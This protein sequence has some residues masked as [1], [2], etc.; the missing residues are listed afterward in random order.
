MLEEDFDETP[1]IEENELSQDDLFDDDNEF[2]EDEDSVEG[3]EESS[4]EEESEEDKAEV[5]RLTE[6]LEK[7]KSRLHDTQQGFHTVCQERAN[8]RKRLEE[9]EAKEADEDEWFSSSDD[10][11]L[12]RVRE[13]YARVEQVEKEAL[14]AA[15][16]VE[17]EQ[18]EKIMAIWESKAR[19]VRNS[20]SDYDEVV[21]WLNEEV[22][23]NPRAKKMWDAVPSKTPA[24]AYALGS[25]LKSF[26]DGGSNTPVR[27]V[28][29]RSALDAVNSSNV[30]SSHKS[31]GARLEDFF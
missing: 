20:H 1:E 12:E 26:F 21:T 8:L 17:Q 18:G 24:E 7:L 28:S 19:A 9:L 6:E 3:E 16:K 15:N 2:L 14:E 5:S 25:R 23:Q 29:N 13:E 31:T 22:T 30:D 11:E 4:E 10:E 27:R